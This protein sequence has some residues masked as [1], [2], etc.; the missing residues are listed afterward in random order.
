MTT[1]TRA[2]RHHALIV[3]IGVVL[4]SPRPALARFIQQGSKLVGSRLEA[5]G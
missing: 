4:L 3:F 5:V 1:G 2:S